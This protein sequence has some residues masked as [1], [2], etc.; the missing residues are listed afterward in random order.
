MDFDASNTFVTDDPQPVAGGGGATSCSNCGNAL[1]AEHVLAGE[2]CA[3][4]GTKNNVPS[5][6]DTAGDEAALRA[7]V[8]QLAWTPRDFAARLAANQSNTG[9]LLAEMRMVA[10]VAD[11][12][13]AAKQSRAHAKAA[14]PTVYGSGGGEESRLVTVP[15]WE[16]NSKKEKWEAKKTQVSD[17][18]G[19]VEQPQFQYGYACHAQADAAGPTRFVVA[20]E[21]GQR[22]QALETAPVLLGPTQS[23][24]EIGILSKSEVI[25]VLGHREVR[26]AV[27]V[28]FAV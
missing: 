16:A 21:A 28:Q 24:K 22:W 8:A 1:N 2:F 25:C 15:L 20:V 4:C 18:P 23:Q 10:S 7:L 3:E 13:G 5:A 9:L 6:A 27:Y 19:V 14:S 11:D 17:N 26:G 12:P